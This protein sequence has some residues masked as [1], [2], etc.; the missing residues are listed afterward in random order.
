MSD[1]KSVYPRIETGY[2]NTEDIHDELVEKFN[3]QSFNQRS[4]KLKIKCYN[5]KNLMVLHLP[6]KER[7]KN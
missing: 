2:A 6:V 1:E 4:G 5:P 3:T 7:V